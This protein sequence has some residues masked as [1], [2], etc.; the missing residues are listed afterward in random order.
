MNTRFMAVMGALTLGAVL[1]QPASADKLGQH[2][3]VLV[4]QKWQTRGIDPN[5]FIVLHPAGGRLLAASPA[6]QVDET[7]E[8]SR[9]A[10]RSEDFEIRRAR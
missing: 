6:V 9:S 4:M 2:P 10:A 8:P 5:T 3:A 7:R 1:A